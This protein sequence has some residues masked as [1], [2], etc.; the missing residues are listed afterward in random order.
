M[1]GFW[2]RWNREF[3]SK[4]VCTVVFVGISYGFPWGEVGPFSGKKMEKMV[5]G[6]V[7]FCLVDR[8][9]LLPFGEENL[10]KKFWVHLLLET[11]GFP[12]LDAAPWCKRSHSARR[13]EM[14]FVGRSVPRWGRSG[15]LPKEKREVD[16]YTV[17]A[18]KL[19]AATILGHHNSFLALPSPSQHKQPTSL[20]QPWALQQII[21]AMKK[22]TSSC[23]G[24]RL[25]MNLLP[26]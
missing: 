16:S 26:S 19:L 7:C 22:M 24:Y 20:P 3:C 1:D 25:G 18:S 4:K 17:S 6:F 12:R 9:C 8:F 21:W 5:I 10:V 14:G 11:A 23:L 13:I 2:P 15:K